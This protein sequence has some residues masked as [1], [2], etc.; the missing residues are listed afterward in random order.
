MHFM[1]WSTITEKCINL[2]CPEDDVFLGVD[3]DGISDEADPADDEPTSTNW[4]LI[5]SAYFTKLS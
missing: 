1:V 3:D 4:T 5:S 2:L